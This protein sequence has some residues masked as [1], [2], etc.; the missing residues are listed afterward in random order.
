MTL[1]TFN[2]HSLSSEDRLQPF[3]I[4]YE[5]IKWDI[6]EL[7]EERRKEEEN[8][9]LASRRVIYYRDTEVD[10]TRSVSFPILKL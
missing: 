3:W 5:K 4:Y 2:E 7:W 8:T 6:L 1:A 10:R 9:D